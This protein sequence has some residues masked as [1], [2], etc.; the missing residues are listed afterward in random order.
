M[1]V[2][3]ELFNW[4]KVNSVGK[5]PAKNNYSGSAVKMNTRVNNF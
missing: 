1:P 5:L 4:S 3:T 2:T